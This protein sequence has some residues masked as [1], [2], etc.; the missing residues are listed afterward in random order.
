MSYLDCVIQGFYQ[1]FGREGVS[2]FFQTT[3]NWDHP[4]LDDR[5]SPQYPRST[6]LSEN[7]V[8]LV[9]EHLENL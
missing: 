5:N 8:N 9:N 2:A 6:I 4:I 1:H 7:E 3:K